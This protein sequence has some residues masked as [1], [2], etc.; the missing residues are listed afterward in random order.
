MDLLFLQLVIKLPLV[1]VI[2][3]SLLGVVEIDSCL[4]VLGPVPAAV[5][6]RGTRAGVLLLTEMSI[7]ILATSLLFL[8]TLI[9]VVAPLVVV[10]PVRSLLIIVRLLF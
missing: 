10:L 6:F 8:A 2:L 1:L 5:I 3:M 7:A 9:Q 4:F